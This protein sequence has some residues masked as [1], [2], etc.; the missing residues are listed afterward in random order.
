ML[1]PRRADEASQRTLLGRGAGNSTDVDPASVAVRAALARGR[2]RMG[3]QGMKDDL[4]NSIERLK[5]AAEKRPS[6]QLYLWIAIGYLLM[7]VVKWGLI[8]GTMIAI[9]IIAWKL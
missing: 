7:Q 4:I 8:A 5:A 3:A 2:R 9:I 6:S 1:L